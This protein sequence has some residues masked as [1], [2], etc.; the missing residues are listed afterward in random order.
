MLKKGTISRVRELYLN[1]IKYKKDITKAIVMFFKDSP[2]SKQGENLLFRSLQE[3]GLFNE[4]IF[5]D[6]KFSDGKGMLEKYYYEN[7]ENIPEY[8]RVIYKNLMENYYGLYEVLEIRLFSGLK[9]KRIEDSRIFDVYEMSL[10]T[11]IN[12]GDVF[13]T[14]VA[15]VGDRYELVG[16]DTCLFQLS[17]LSENQRM[18]QLKEF[19]K[20][21]NLTPRDAARMINR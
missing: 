12:I 20:L 21:K 19:S 7:P 1:D 13:F 17:R 3:E 10:T 8:R 6:F 9:L 4:W 2:Y 16:A 5:Y 15:N 11:Q 14:R 18:L